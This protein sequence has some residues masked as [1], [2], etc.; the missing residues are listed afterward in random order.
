VLI[1]LIICLCIVAG[2][3]VMGA[4]EDGAPYGAFLAG[5]VAVALGLATVGGYAVASA[6]EQSDKVECVTRWVRSGTPSKY[7]NGQCLIEVKPGQYLPE[8]MLLGRKP[9]TSVIPIPI[10]IFLPR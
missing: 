8:E 6:I 2:A 7:E 9:E 10:P 1:W 4:L 3:F 5:L